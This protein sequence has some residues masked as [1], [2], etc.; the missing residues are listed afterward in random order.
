MTKLQRKAPLNPV[1][2][3]FLGDNM[4]DQ[5]EY[6]KEDLIDEITQET[7]DSF[8]LNES[9]KSILADCTNSELELIRSILLKTG[10]NT[11]KILNE[12]ELTDS[13]QFRNSD[14]L[15][16]EV[17][18]RF[19]VGTKLMDNIK[20]D[21]K[22]LAELQ[23]R[24]IYLG[25]GKSTISFYMERN[26]TI[27]T[28]KIAHFLQE[29]ESGNIVRSTTNKFDDN[30]QELMT[31]AETPA[32]KRFYKRF[33]QSFHIGE[34]NKCLLMLKCIE[35][36]NN[37]GNF[38]ITFAMDSKNVKKEILKHNELF[39]LIGTWDNCIASA[40]NHNNSSALH[41]LRKQMLK[42]WLIAAMKHN[43]STLPETLLLSNK[44][45]L[46]KLK[47]NDFS[48]AEIKEMVGNKILQGKRL[49]V[50][51]LASEG[52][53]DE[54]MLNS[55]WDTGIPNFNKF[56]APFYY[57]YKALRAD[58]SI[59]QFNFIMSAL[60]EKEDIYI[61]VELLHE[62]IQ[63][64]ASN[65]TDNLK[66]ILLILKW[67]SKILADHN[68]PELNHFLPN[69]LKALNSIDFDNVVNKSVFKN[70]EKKQDFLKKYFKD[71]PIAHKHIQ[72]TEENN[73]TP[74]H[75]EEDSLALILICEE[76]EILARDLQQYD[77]ALALLSQIEPTEK[78]EAILEL[79]EY[80]KKCKRLE[81]LS[82]QSG[83]EEVVERNDIEKESLRTVFFST[84]PKQKPQILADIA[85]L[86][87]KLIPLKENL[88]GTE[89]SRFEIQYQF[90]NDLVS[91]L[92]EA[93]FWTEDKY[94]FFLEEKCTEAN[95]HKMELVLEVFRNCGIGSSA[96][97]VPTLR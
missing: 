69:L 91:K 8:L 95:Y 56:L 45:D 58:E 11:L 37:A 72:Q 7:S 28:L 14:E 25:R 78:D 67:M 55:L 70:N 23:N 83:K 43:I 64:I 54:N 35:K 20:K 49:A 41:L 62:S 3:L 80:I 15:H 86:L 65:R 76:A 6:K 89:V 57:Y 31:Q 29:I 66:N 13:Y 51:M 75:H 39:D 21:G 52:I 85:L 10:I 44:Y 26:A 27:L 33:Y 18:D 42:K 9:H 73:T 19:Y 88:K 68:S 97:S 50:R 90:V 53:L 74:L 77:K 22:K 36:R 63:G 38:E 59:N 24:F 82:Q 61:V 2:S 93:R 71:M 92:R 47:S 30:I 96:K 81:I 5:N 34:I 87:D 12:Q 48:L 17:F 40:A 46:P 60:P 79:I 16:L 1:K 94:L 4:Q 32:S 84:G